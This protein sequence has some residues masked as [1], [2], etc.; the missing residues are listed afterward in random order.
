LPTRDLLRAWLERDQ[1]KQHPVFHYIARASTGSKA[2]TGLWCFHLKRSRS[3]SS[4]KPPA[5]EIRKKGESYK[6]GLCLDIDDFNGL[7]APHP[8]R[9]SIKPKSV[10][11]SG[12]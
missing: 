8:I 2:A 9:A 12:C 7:N 3:S 5:T 10:A 6:L 1:E 11:S 4:D